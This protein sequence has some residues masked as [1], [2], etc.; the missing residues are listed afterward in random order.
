MNA[1]TESMA[2]YSW[3]F[4]FIAIF[5]VSGAIDDVRNKNGI[6]LITVIDVVTSN[7][8]K[9][10]TLQ[11]VRSFNTH[12]WLMGKQFVLMYY[13]NQVDDTLYLTGL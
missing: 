10:D 5:K 7:R 13:I 8:E 6:R 9:T 4:L 11:H 2:G 12:F 1:A 3:V